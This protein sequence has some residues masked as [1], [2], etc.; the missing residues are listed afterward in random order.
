MATLPSLNNLGKRRIGQVSQ[1][2][3]NLEVNN[4]LLCCV[5][6]KYNAMCTFSTT[7]DLTRFTI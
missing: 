2:K 4:L 6:L 1:R 5:E 3:S 7:F